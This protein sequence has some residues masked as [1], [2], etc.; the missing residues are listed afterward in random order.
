MPGCGAVED[1]WPRNRRC[2]ISLQLHGHQGGFVFFCSVLLLSIFRL[3]R[4]YHHACNESVL[5]WFHRKRLCHFFLFLL[6]NF[7]LFFT[8]YCA[9]FENIIKCSWHEDNITLNFICWLGGRWD[10]HNIKYLSNCLYPAVLELW[11]RVGTFV[12]HRVDGDSAGCREMAAPAPVL[13]G[14]VLGS[15]GETGGSFNKLKPA[16]WLSLSLCQGRFCHEFF[17][18]KISAVLYFIYFATYLPWQPLCFWSF[19]WV[20]CLDYYHEHSAATAV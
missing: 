14:S 4:I 20:F 11:A 6:P 9:H 1:T 7:Y 5:S 13:R 18:E 15:C 2:L 12:S 16:P 19:F 10:K 8:D 3:V 17:E